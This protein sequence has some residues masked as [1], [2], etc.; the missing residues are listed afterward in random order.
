MIPDVSAAF[1]I[2]GTVGE[3]AA[4]GKESFFSGRMLRVYDDVVV[5]VIG[6]R[7]MYNERRL[8]SFRYNAITVR[9]AHS[10]GNACQVYYSMES[11]SSARELSSKQVD[12]IWYSFRSY[13]GS[14]QSGVT[15][16]FVAFPW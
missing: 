2:Y 16:I 14:F 3:R 11:L 8:Y 5:V 1:T 12:S 13:A 10:G 15:A 7:T 4:S 6:Q 9:I